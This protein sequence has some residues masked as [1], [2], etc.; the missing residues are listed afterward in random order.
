MEEEIKEIHDA[1]KA[2]SKACLMTAFPGARC[3]IPFASSEAK[4]TQQS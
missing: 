1:V 4:T 3:K 2:N